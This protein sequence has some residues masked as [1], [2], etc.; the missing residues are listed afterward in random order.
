VV[1]EIAELIQKGGLMMYIPIGYKFILGIVL[2]VA[3]VAFSPSAVHTLGYSQEMSTVFAFAVALTAGLILG[4]LLS[5]GL[6][7]N[8]RVITNA[9]EAISEGDLSTD[10]A[11]KT[12]RFP[13]ETT[14]IATAVNLMTENLRGLVSQLRSASGHVSES[15]HTLSSTTLEVNATTEEIAKALEQIS[16]G[17]EIQA[18]MA[19]KGATL[20][21]ELAVSVELVAKRA[22]ESAQSARDTTASAQQGNE[23]VKQTMDLM[24]EFLN[25]VEYTGQQ[26]AELNGK[27]QQ[28]GK[29]AD[30]IVE[31][32]RQ[33]N[34]LALN[35]SIEAVRAGEY[36][37]GFTVVAEEVRKL[38][39]GTSRS[40]SEIIDLVTLIK[41]DSI[42]VRET[43]ASSS[44]QI[45]EGKK[46]I[47]STAE[48]FQSIVQ[49]VVEAERKAT[50]IADLSSM[51]TDGAQKMV[52]TIDEIAKVAEDNAAATE[53]VSAATEEQS[54]AMQ[55]MAAA[56]RE[57][58]AL[59]ADLL[60][61]VE[62]FRL[63]ED[64][65]ADYE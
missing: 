10:V 50:S 40:A 22:R 24:K 42:K 44:R 14:D 46:K 28:V 13:D 64:A 33:T 30:I 27:L 38:A 5:K 57:L 17:A 49:T 18:D 45:N 62:R 15:A 34:M 19:G 54:A 58:S 4:W 39:D 60:Q 53:Q 32:A 56:S 21:H 35:A 20:I 9:V 3:A 61:A 6:S 65:P 41:E 31:I 26:F 55:E 52:K 59:S 25:T 16:H 47:N 8:I 48:V 29:I 7:K 2:V 12:K 63:P 36:G 23:L 37:K 43:F 11:V 51:Q 1:T